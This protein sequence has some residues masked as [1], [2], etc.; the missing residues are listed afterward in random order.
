MWIAAN[1]LHTALMQTEINKHVH[2]Q[3]N[4][5][6][7]CFQ[8]ALYRCGV[9]YATPGQLIVA[10]QYLLLYAQA[11][12]HSGRG[13]LPDNLQLQVHSYLVLVYLQRWRVVF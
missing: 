13:A 9:Q 3:T 8:P 7:L 10:F 5:M 1:L 12:Q 2:M 4:D 6:Y 11:M